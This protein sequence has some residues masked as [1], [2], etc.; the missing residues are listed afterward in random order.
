VPCSTALAVPGFGSRRF[1]CRTQTYADL[2]FVVCS[3]GIMAWTMC[4]ATTNR[5]WRTALWF[6]WR[7]VGRF[8][9]DHDYCGS[10]TTARSLLPNWRLPWPTNSDLAQR[11][12]TARCI[13]WWRVRVAALW[14]VWLLTAFFHGAVTNSGAGGFCWLGCLR[15]AFC[16]HS[17]LLTCAS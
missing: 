8:A 14:L 15:N 11:C 12:R 16:R 17:A 6:V 5:T 9:S 2:W 1:N 4:W 10:G 3:D 7:A 13:A